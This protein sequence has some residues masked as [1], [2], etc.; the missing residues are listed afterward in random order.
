M[1]FQG[2]REA[3]Y[4]NMQQG[5]WFIDNLLSCSFLFNPQTKPLKKGIT[6]TLPHLLKSGYSTQKQVVSTP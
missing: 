2:I 6:T 4:G 1:Y 5:P 3:I